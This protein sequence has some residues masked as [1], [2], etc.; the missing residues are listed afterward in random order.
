MLFLKR[1]S[2]LFDQRREELERGVLENQ[3][4]V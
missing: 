1:V 2:D 3:G 4:L